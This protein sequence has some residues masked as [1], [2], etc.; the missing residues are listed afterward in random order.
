MVAPAPSRRLRSL[1]LGGVGGC[2]LTACAAPSAGGGPVFYRPAAIGSQATFDPLRSGAQYVLDGAQIGD[3]GT[4]DFSAKLKAVW[5]HLR[6]PVHT[7]EHDEGW[8]DFVNSELLPIDPDHFGDSRAIL[9]NVFLHTVG[10]GMLYRKYAEWFEAHDVPLPWLSAGLVAMATEVLGEASEKPVTDDTDEIA[11]VLIY[12]P[13]GLWLFQDP[14]RACWVRDHLRP[15]DWPYQ[16]VWDVDD[17]EFANVGMNYALRPT[18]FGGDDTLPFV[19]LGITNLFGLSHRVGCGDR[20]SWGAGTATV[21]VKP[22]ELRWSAGV[23]YDRDDSLLASLIVN[24]ADGYAVRANVYPGVLFGSTVPIGLF[25]GVD[26][27]GRGTIGAQ[28][29]LPIGVAR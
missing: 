24:G 13:L 29:V 14:A 3:A 17:G 6:E 19:H 4:G 21:T 2:L 16:L 5:D 9:P 18:L 10:G 27:D 12:R 8:R 23:F 22:V 7:I 20:L 1:A 28:W 26:D 25:V 11:D 15:V